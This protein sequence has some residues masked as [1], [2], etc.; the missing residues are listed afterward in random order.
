[1]LRCF[2]LA[3]LALLLPAAVLP[4]QDDDQVESAG[5]NSGGGAFI[6]P[7]HILPQTAAGGRIEWRPDW[8]ADIPVDTFDI[9]NDDGARRVSAVTLSGK[10]IILTARRDGRGVFTEFPVFLNGGFY[11]FGTKFDSEGKIRGFTTGGEDQMEIEFLAFGNQGG[12]PSLARIHDGESWFFA[13]I[14]YRNGL[15]LETWYDVDGN[16]L[17]V[18]TV[19][20]DGARPKSYRSV[21]QAAPDSE[22]TDDAED[23]AR[24]A[25]S[26]S[27]FYFDSMGN[28]T[29]IDRDG[30]VFEALYK[31]SVPRYWKGPEP[32]RLALQWDGQ[33]RLVRMTGFAGDDAPLDYRYEYEFDGQGAWTERREVR[34]TPGLGVLLPARGD[35][36][37]RSLEYR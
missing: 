25:V 30:G 18:F 3:C 22:N 20:L 36:F 1:M 7:V 33:G 15:I 11:Q 19:E 6:F 37:S 13:S 4:A 16:P 23:G 26:E 14:L 34:M 24:P 10:E 31:G 5:E 8:P 12:E 2:V 28:T 29:R 9:L 27:R 32:G 35:S 21:F 17:A